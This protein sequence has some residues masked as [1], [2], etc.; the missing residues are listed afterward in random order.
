VVITWTW[1]KKNSSGTFLL[2]IIL[3]EQQSKPRRPG[4]G[5]GALSSL[6]LVRDLKL[7][8]SISDDPLV[9]ASR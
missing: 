3:Q 4:R 7:G 9:M 1:S 5:A 6:T 2:L 8:D